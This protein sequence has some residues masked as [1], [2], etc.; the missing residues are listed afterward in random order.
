MAI[1]NE[2]ILVQRHHELSPL[3]FDQKIFLLRRDF[4]LTYLNNPLLFLF[5]KYFF[6]L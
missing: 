6:Q 5:K 1:T 3:N 4:L 2:F